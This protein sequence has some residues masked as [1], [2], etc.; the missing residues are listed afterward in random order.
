MGNRSGLIALADG[1]R[2]Y[3]EANGVAAVIPPVGLKYRTFQINQGP[4]GGSRVVFIPGE[5]D[6][7]LEPKAMRAG[8]LRKPRH[9]ATDDINPRELVWWRKSVTLSIWAVDTT[10]L[11]SEQ[12]QWA[13]L[14]DLF[15]STVQAVHNA[16]DPVSGLPVG[17]A[18]VVW[19]NTTL[20]RTVIENSFGFELLV[21]LTHSGPLF[22]LPIEQ[23][24][25]QPSVA[26]VPAA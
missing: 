14:E 8:E 6:G 12:A 26:R 1:A 11:A 22:D 19:V 16:R 21:T 9:N 15:E 25:P 20:N 24:F 10:N 13:A 2:A 5:Y 23:A 17:L 18:D 3:F 4:G 7:Q